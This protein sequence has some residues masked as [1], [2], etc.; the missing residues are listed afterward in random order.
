MQT[1]WQGLRYGART[2]LKRCVFTWTAGATLALGMGAGAAIFDVA[3]QDS[4]IDLSMARQYFSEAEA[5]CRRD[6][7]KLWGV[8]LC[9]PMLFVDA[10]TRAVVANQGDREGRLKSSGEVFVGK[11]PNQMNIANTAVEW[12]GVKWATMIWP[13]PADQFDRAGFMYP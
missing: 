11:L 8:S 4:P 7:G 12:A 10:K 1:L 5:S 3:A 9:G 6:N 2:L 13:L